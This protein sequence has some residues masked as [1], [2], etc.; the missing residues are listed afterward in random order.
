LPEV[1]NNIVLSLAVSKPMAEIQVVCEDGGNNITEEKPYDPAAYEI[2]LA[3]CCPEETTLGI[4]EI[5]TEE[6]SISHEA[7]TDPLS[8]HTDPVSIIML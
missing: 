2:K 7:S 8:D 5:D 3:N 6:L 4:R 1:Y